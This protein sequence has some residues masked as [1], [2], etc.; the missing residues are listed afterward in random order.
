MKFKSIEISGFKSFADKLN[1]SFDGGMTAIVGPN[2]C[3]KSNVADSIRWVLGEQSSKML[4]GSSMQDVIF[5]GTEKRKSL[6]YCEVSLVFDNSDHFFNIDF[7]EI[8]ISRKLYRS[9]ESE[10]YLNRSQ[11]RLKDIVDLLHDSGIGKEGYSIIG[12]G[13]VEE[14]IAAKPENRRA[15]FEEAAG[16]SKFKFKKIEAER[17]LERTKENLVRLND[18]LSEVNRQ[19]GP[20]KKQREDALKYLDLK[21]E[22]KDLEI[23]SYIYQ[24]DNASSI[25]EKI[26]NILSG[27]KEEIF[28]KES[29][30]NSLDENYDLNMEEISHIDNE[31]NELHNKVLNLTVGLEK[32]AGELKLTSER[33][34]FLKQQNT[35]IIES[36]EKAK[37]NLENT[38]ILSDACVSKK[39][40][41]TDNLEKLEKEEKD[42]TN[43]YLQIVSELTSGEDDIENSQKEMFEKLNKLGDTKA[44]LSTLETE[45]ILTQDNLKELEL[46]LKDVDINLGKAENQKQEQEQVITNLKNKIAELKS[47]NY[48]IT[49][50]INELNDIIKNNNQFKINTY[51]SLQVTENRLRLLKEMQNEYEGYLSSVKRLLKDSERDLYLKNK[52]VGVVANLIKVPAKYEVAIEM[53][54]GSAVQNIVTKDEDDAKNLINY[55]KQNSYGRATFLPISSIKP[56]VFDYSYNKS[57]NINGCFGVASELIDY[58]PKIN[59]VISNL[60]GTT[61]IVDNIET[62]VTLAKDTRYGFKIVTLDGD[63]INPQGSLTGG[64]KKAEVT[65]LISRDREIDK[66]NKD[67]ITYKSKLEEISDILQTSQENLKEN[68]LNQEKLVKE[69]S[70]NEIQYAVE[71]EKL[72]NLQISFENFDKEKMTLTSTKLK[73]VDKIELI[74]TK[75]NEIKGNSTEISSD[76]M[77]NSNSE[78][79]NYLRKQRDELNAKNID[80][81]VQI[82]DLKAQLYNLETEESRLFDLTIDYEDEIKNINKN[83]EESNKIVSSVERLYNDQEVNNLSSKDQQELNAIKSRQENLANDK[84]TLQAKLKEIDEER[85]NLSIELTKVNDKKYNEEFKLQKVDTELD[86]MKERILEEYQLDYDSCQEFK[87]EEFNFEEGNSKINKIKKDIAKLGYVNVN[88][89]EDTKS[90][91]ERYGDLSSQIED[92]NTSYNELNDIISDLSKEMVT[93]F[94]T[95]F[96]KINNNFTKTFKELFGGG[97]A[98]LQLQD[99]GN[100]LESGVE[101]IAQ[102][103]GKKLASL[104][105]LSGGE[106]ALTAIAILFAILRLKPLP[107]CLLDEIEAALDDANAD[108]FASYLKRFSNETQFI[109]ITHRKP[110][111]ELADN[112]YGVTMEEKGVSKMVSV[113]LSDA[114]KDSV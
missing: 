79:F 38:K 12:Q 61:V 64:S 17:K 91:E 56:R 33:L 40:E 47:N 111:M 28:I 93:K 36:L 66:L 22:L 76:E 81:K 89:I 70:Q 24:Y 41:L 99:D 71:Q 73:L 60:L 9:G 106:K 37:S 13:K 90:L 54:L 6:S 7:D 51:S 30:L 96:E 80:I 110:T 62:A 112:L 31:V 67:I 114:I 53:A 69:I 49:L 95:E 34:N 25:K 105:L 39:E 100:L 74:E 44:K 72:E 21:S 84:N 26:N 82:S 78:R 68:N 48:A 88:A 18:I 92:L 20:L 52:I 16:I 103:P 1:I 4:R 55:L 14:I 108:R 63:I 5:N 87:K 77:I 83:L 101:I 104:T 15:I 10:Y 57:L 102:P 43:K 98:Y 86:S 2:G 3:G 94:K 85:K 58:D 8:V 59:N 32:Q 107:F 109:V 75:Y 50:K 11:C 23:N 97:N 45:K 65:N 19:L 113:K 42:I 27:I 35:Q 29:K 46:K